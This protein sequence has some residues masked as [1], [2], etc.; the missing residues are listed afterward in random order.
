MMLLVSLV[1]CKPR[2]KRGLQVD[3]ARRR[4]MQNRELTGN[5]L[6]ATRRF[7]VKRGLSILRNF[8][9]SLLESISSHNRFICWH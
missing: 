7:C 6:F 3:L 4:G 9:R 1:A 5:S 2:S 8:S